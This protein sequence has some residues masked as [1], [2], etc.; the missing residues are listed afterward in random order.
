VY[1]FIFVLIPRHMPYLL[2]GAVVTLQLSFISMA[3]GVALG[4]LIALGRLSGN[5][6]LNGLLYAYVEV[7]RDVPLIV[8][9]LVIYFTLPQ[10][11]IVLPGFWAGVLG[12]SLN[13]AA[14]LSEVFR[15]AIISVDEGQKDAGLSIGMSRITV[16]RRVVLPQAFRVAIPTVGGYFISLLKDSSLV[17]FI[18]V[19]ELLRHGT[20]VIANTFR[21]ME[22]YFMVAMIYFV[23]SFVAARVVYRLEQYLT[24]AYL[25]A[26]GRTLARNPGLATVEQVAA[27]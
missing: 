16:Y 3:C 4:M 17:S 9:L 2:E 24:P 25:R 7:W 10:I 6:W 14:Y 26:A 19:D 22:T 5:R 13:M 23:M 12:L 27:P 20:I 1:N 15:A 11:G 8:Q 21:S 18:A